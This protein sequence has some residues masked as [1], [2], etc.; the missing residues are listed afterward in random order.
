MNVQPRLP[1]TPDDFLLWNEER[2]GRREFVDGRV[3]EMMINTT[4]RHAVLATRLAA[5]LLRLF[6]YPRFFVGT[7]DVAVRTERGI[8]YPDVFVDQGTPEHVDRELVAEH[9][10]FLAEVLSAS[11]LGRDFV[12]K[13][14]EYTAIPSL[15]FYVVAAQDEPRVWF[16]ARTGDGWTKREIFGADEMID[17]D[18]GKIALS[19]LY[20]GIGQRA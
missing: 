12:D 7:S 14:G 5:A 11:S 13:A 8:R 20:A 17:L 19:E 9:P 18:E 10:I 4:I 3:V 1:A 16:W 2:E 15:R 6:P